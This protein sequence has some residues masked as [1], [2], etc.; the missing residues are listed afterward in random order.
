M[1]RW[2]RAERLLKGSRGRV[3]DV[4]CAFGFGTRRLARRFAAVGIDVSPDYIRRAA[5][6]Q[7]RARFLL[8]S[9]SALPF[10]ASS[11][12]AAVALDVLEHVPNERLFIAELERALRPGAMLILSVPHRGLLA[13]FDSYNVCSTLLDA[14]E[15]APGREHET[16]PLHRHYS[17][18]ELRGLLQSGFAIDRVE[19]SGLGLAEFVNILLLA[20]CKG[21]L[22]SQRLYNWLQYLYFSVYLIE[23]L[24][25]CGRFSY[26][27]IL[28]ARRRLAPADAQATVA[29]LAGTAGDRREEQE[30][31]G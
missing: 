20:A 27:I 29:N 16:G 10:A 2:L 26:H 1:A 3:L 11:F 24:V 22:K 6:S 18:A 12:D 14:S 8:A 7:S 25:P 23:D 5:R 19:L 28:R 13:R 4:G 31:P 9:G 30:V 21:L 17:Q 15:L